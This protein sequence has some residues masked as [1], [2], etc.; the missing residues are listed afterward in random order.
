MKNPRSTLWLF[1][2]AS[3]LL[4]FPYL[5]GRLE[6]EHRNHTVIT[7]A[8]YESFKAAARK[9]GMET[10][11]LLLQLKDSGISTVAIRTTEQFE[12]AYSLHAAGFTILPVLPL[13]GDSL[14][15]YHPIFERWLHELPIRNIVIK[16][17]KN[18]WISSH[19]IYTLEALARKYNLLAGLVEN[20]EQT[21]PILQK[22]IRE[23]IADLKFPVC[24]VYETPV[25]QLAEL[26]GNALF[27]RWLRGV[28]DRNIRLI[29]ITPLQNPSLSPEKNLEETLSATGDLIKFLRTRGYKVNVPLPKSDVYLPDKLHYGILLVSLLSVLYLYLQY[30]LNFKSQQRSLLAVLAFAFLSLL[31]Y[32]FLPLQY[33]EYLAILAAILYPSLCSLLIDRFL[34]LNCSMPFMARLAIPLGIFI[35]TGFLGAV[36]ISAALSDIRH[37]MAMDVFH[38]VIP[39]LL[40]PLFLFTVYFIKEYAGKN[41]FHRVAENIRKNGL[42][43]KHIAFAAVSMF[44][45]YLYLARSGNAS[46]IPPSPVELEFRKLLE[47]LLLARP[48]FKE[49]LI[50]Y[51][52]LFC[53]AYLPNRKM[54]TL[55]RYLLGIGVCIGSISIMNSFCHVFTTITV[56]LQRTLYGLGL[57]IVAGT[58]TV[59]LVYL[60][61]KKSDGQKQVSG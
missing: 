14:Q 23:L 22:D 6:N 36:T 18:T 40:S 48:R 12:S 49:F 47:I 41:S 8:D 1:A 61:T 20:A 2:I 43:W 16:Q 7:A 53:L 52:A 30:L 27:F 24:R 28:V 33:P 34:H 37:I 29:Y 39:A 10:D 54:N 51:P 55:V 56:S 21:G 15:K 57:G 19:E 9:T 3:L 35:G 45:L 60:Y 17:D 4:T 13:E 5:A 11:E 50:G 31:F 26:R 25:E 32:L 44:A 38:L 42:Q 46:L 58:A 59:I